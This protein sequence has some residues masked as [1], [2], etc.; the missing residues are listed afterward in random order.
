M[1]RQSAFGFMPEVF[2]DGG[3]YLL[4]TDQGEGC[5]ILIAIAAE[6]NNIV[7]SPKS[8][9]LLN[10]VSRIFLQDNLQISLQ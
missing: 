6:Q 2:T 9:Y 8:Q 10:M 5:G 4:F 7:S 1:D 3:R